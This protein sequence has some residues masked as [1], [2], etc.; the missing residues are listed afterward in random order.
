MVGRE[1]IW[2]AGL[3]GG[4][5]AHRLADGARQA[6]RDLALE[7]NASPA[8]VWSDGE[9][10]WVADWLGDAVRA[11][12]LADGA[13]QAG[14]DI[15]LSGENLMPAGVW[16]D[17]G[18]LMGGGLAGA[19]VRVPAGGRPES[20]ATGHHCK[21]GDADPTGVWSGGGTL[22][23]TGWEGREVRAYRCRSPGPRRPGGGLQATRPGRAAL[24]TIGDPGLR[25][26][27]RRALGK[28]P[29]E[30]V[31]RGDLAG[32][33]SLHARNAG[34]RDLAGLEAAKGLKELDL[35]FNPLGTCG[36]WRRCRRWS[37]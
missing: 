25:A 19:A 22:L 26:A 9:T 27:V 2:V 3:E 10:A 32:L 28:Q 6:A 30:A 18:N 33:E 11:Y 23:S 21:D 20:A 13:R 16:S 24:P 14:R 4:L 36:N 17:G 31:R 29:G 34:V 5:R 7:A 8:G 12:R 1:T 37:R 35:G 15:Q